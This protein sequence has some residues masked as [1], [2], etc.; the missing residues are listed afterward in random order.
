MLKA[1][2]LESSPRLPVSLRNQEP[3]GVVRIVQYV[4][5]VKPWQ[6]IPHTLF[7]YDMRWSRMIL[8]FAHSSRPQTNLT[9]DCVITILFALHT[10]KNNMQ[11]NGRN[12][13]PQELIREP[14]EQLG[15]E[16]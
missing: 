14:S 15:I 12:L 1:Q 3:I 9:H 13:Q 10:Q 8:P 4:L 2:T 7:I 16:T 5:S 11:F 6:Y